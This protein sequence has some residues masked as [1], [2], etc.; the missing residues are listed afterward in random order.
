VSVPKRAPLTKVGF[1]K[2]RDE[3]ENLARIERPRVVKG[4]SDAAAEGDRSEN[5]EYIYGKKK[6]REIDRRLSYLSKLLRNVQ[7]IDPNTLFG[8]K[9]IFGA[10][11]I[12]IDESGTLKKW[13]IVGDGEADSRHGTISLGS[14]VARAL[15]GKFVGD[16][17]EVQ[18]P[19]GTLEYEVVGIKFGRR[20]SAGR[21]K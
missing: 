4:V 8:N 16:V 14:P 10:T 20:L 1:E 7:V 19:R 9:I 17:V 6:L 12:V 18:L 21:E 2:L 13:T 3:Y 11:A 5:A 15:I